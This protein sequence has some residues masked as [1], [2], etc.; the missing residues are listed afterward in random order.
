MKQLHTAIWIILWLGSA[1]SHDSLMGSIWSEKLN[2]VWKTAD[3]WLL[4]QALYCDFIFTMKDLL[5][6]TDITLLQ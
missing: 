4:F 3:C 6:F 1:G 2:F 5:H